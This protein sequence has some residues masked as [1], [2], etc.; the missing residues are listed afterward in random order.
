M[1]KIIC[2]LS[3]ISSFF[4]YSQAIKQEKDIAASMV[5]GF[6][7]GM[8]NTLE[9][10]YE[11]E[12]E[13][14]SD[15]IK[16]NLLK[17]TK[18]PN[19]KKNAISYLK[20][21]TNSINY[22]ENKMDSIKIECKFN[23]LVSSKEEKINSLKEIEGFLKGQISSPMLENVLSFEYQNQPHKE[24]VNGYTYT[25]NTK[26]HK[27][28]KNSE[29][30]IEIP[31]SWTAR[32]GRQPNVIQLFTSDCGNGDYTIT[33]MTGEMPFSNDEIDSLSF[34]EIDQIYKDTFT[35]EFAKNFTNGEFISYKPMKIAGRSGF[36]VVYEEINE[37]MG[38]KMK[39]RIN[40]YIFHDVTNLHFI[41]CGIVSPNIAENL[42]EKSTII[43]PLFFM[44]VN[45]IVVP[46][47]NND[48][49]ELKGTEHQKIIDVK[50]AETNFN[51]IFDTG[52]TVSLISK[53]IINNLLE[54]GVIS[55]RN[56]LE[57]KYIM[58]ADG[59]KHLVELWNLPEIKIGDKKINNVDFAVMDGDI[60]PLLGMNIINRLNIYKI[61]LEN[62]KI[63]LKSEN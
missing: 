5:Y 57:K 24:F 41:N 43:N 46:K 56:F 9:S 28:A 45:S 53:S 25:Y 20:N 17:T 39:M 23:V 32:E 34:E 15:V 16:L 29:I 40:T 19:S 14:R 27:K 2:V 4:S 49:I 37:K 47:K 1:K 55:N 58:T 36:L 7:I 62:Y 8:E 59:K 30:L 38:M 13:L 60:K 54:Y 31:K 12:P 50:I 42:A 6:F 52:A 11:Y 3:I 63:Y 22:F 21:K 61:D 51:F 18:F 10:I 44:I 35:E 48:I 33:I 26:G